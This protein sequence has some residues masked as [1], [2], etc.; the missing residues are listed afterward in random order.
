M[1]LCKLQSWLLVANNKPYRATNYILH[2]MR[3]CTQSCVDA[4]L[5]N[6]AIDWLLQSQGEEAAG[7]LIDAAHRAVRLGN[8]MICLSKLQ[9]K[10][11]FCSPFDSRFGWVQELDGDPGAVSMWYTGKINVKDEANDFAALGIKFYVYTNVDN[12]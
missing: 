6:G 8:P 5:D 3:N 4:V 12:C 2:E 7:G 10:S 11:V 9:D 1:R